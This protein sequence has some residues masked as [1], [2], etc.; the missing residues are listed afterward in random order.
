MEIVNLLLPPFIK[1]V[2]VI[3]I[4]LTGVAYAT[5]AE[6]KFC[7]YIQDRLGPNRVGPYGLLQ[8]VADGLKFFFKEDIT[9][10]NVYK[11]LYFLAPLASLV[12][13]LVTFAV[14]PFGENIS[15]G[16]K[17][18]RM[19]I[20]ERMDLGVVYLIAIS[21]IGVYGIF[22]AGLSS[23]NK[24]SL[25][26]SLR[27]INQV[28]SYEIALGLGILPIALTSK[29]FNLDEIVK[30]QQSNVWFVLPHFIAFLIFLT[31]VFAETN[32]LPFD[33]PE[34]ENELVGGY[35]T[36]YSGL[37]FAMFFMGEYANMIT[38]SALLTIFFFGGWNIP[39][40]NYN[41]FGVTL[42]GIIS[43]I[44]F[45]VKV[46]IFVIFFIWVRWT[47]PRFRYDQVMRIMWKGLL[48]IGF[49]YL[50]VV[51]VYFYFVGA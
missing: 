51:A 21:S 24:Y 34:G 1:I 20:A 10:K 45:C 26:G 48:P 7:A 8:P 38:A 29:G 30:M 49:L 4:L 31:A 2:V 46:S 15:I 40:V 14:I 17:T 35:H 42:G 5:Y 25:L 3:T 37:R 16:S 11:P 18:Y 47:L 50:M 33:L 22:L 41:I 23:N 39:F 19:L 27:S 43:A 13:A 12:P 28:V 36:E 44:V 9:P 32:R 6:R